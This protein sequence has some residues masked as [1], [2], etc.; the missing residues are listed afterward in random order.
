M[1]DSTSGV[2]APHSKS[3]PDSRVPVGLGRL[4]AALSPGTRIIHCQHPAGGISR[5]THE[6]KHEERPVRL[7]QIQTR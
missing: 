1:T 2:C 7:L 6:P 4:R 5:L 3:R